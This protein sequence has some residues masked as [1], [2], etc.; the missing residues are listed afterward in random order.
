MSGG[1]GD[2]VALGQQVEHLPHLHHLGLQQESAGVALRRRTM[3]F[4]MVRLG[5]LA[6][7]LARVAGLS[8]RGPLA[9]LAL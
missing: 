3:L 5:H 9:T 2:F 6:Q 1:L 8:A 7:G 4:H